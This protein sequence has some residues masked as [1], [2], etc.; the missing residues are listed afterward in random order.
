MRRRTAVAGY[1]YPS[2]KKELLGFIQSNLSTCEKTDAAA[3]LVPHAGYI[4][5]GSTAVNTLSMI[6]IPDTVILAG[7]NH[8]GAGAGA[9]VYPEGSWETPL[10][11][12]AVDGGV[13]EALCSGGLFQRD[14][15]AHKSEHSLEVIVPILKYLNPNVR[16]VCI[17]MKFMELDRVKECAEAVFDAVRGKNAL[18]VVSSD[19]NHF[20]N[21]QITEKKDALAI[22]SI[23]KMDEKLL[24]QRIFEYNISMCGFLPACMGLMYC[25]ILGD[26]EPHLVEHTHSGAVNGDNARVVGYAG[27]I[28]KKKE[29]S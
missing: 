5:S 16:I 11:D 28:F 26:Y 7:P 15:R 27:I 2:D 25:K 12:A 22:D 9:S 17:T 24:F 6:N 23:L 14:D 13:V 8:T 21:T 10:G 3:V 18:L 4:Y 20:E 1:F 29:M 19:F